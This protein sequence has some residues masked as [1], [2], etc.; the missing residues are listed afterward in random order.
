LERQLEEKERRWNDE[1]ETL[2][3]SLERFKQSALAAGTSNC[4]R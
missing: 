2:R 4:C 1:V 3:K